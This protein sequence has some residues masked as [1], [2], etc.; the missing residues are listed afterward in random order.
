MDNSSQEVEKKKKITEVKTF[1]V[2]FPL[3]E[4]QEN[5][6]I[7]TN[8]ASKPSQEEILNQAFQFHSQGNISKATKSYQYFINQGFKDHRVFA[9]YGAILA[10]S[11]K[12]QEAELF[13]RKA[14]ELNPDYAKAYS[15]LG[16]IL[17]DKGKLQEAEFSYRKAIELSPDFAEAHSNL[18]NTLR[19]LRKLQEA[20]LFTRKAIEM[21]PDFAEAYS[22]LGN[23]LKDRGKLQEAEF[24]YRKAIE[25]S[26]DFA[27]AHSNLGNV[28]RDLG[29]LKD[30]R[31]CSEKIM[32]L[33]S[34]SILGSYSFNHEM[35]LD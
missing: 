1:T 22:N 20:E 19:D 14:I 2:P 31:L 34:W 3:R 5:I 4:N 18:G 28:L 30:A 10:N 16:R 23:I 7:T 13:T 35:K 27:E 25:L 9:N 32:Y 24:S 21:S 12:S 29:K 11:G 33:R 8:T 15:N 17:K 6:I 26:P